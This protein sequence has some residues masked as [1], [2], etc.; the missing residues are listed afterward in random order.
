MRLYKTTAPRELAQLNKGKNMEFTFK[1]TEQ[2][3]NAI[4]AGLQELPARVA[5]PLSQKLQQQAQ[6]QLP[7]QEPQE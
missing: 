6:E 2:E 7:K 1:V 5:N 4:L 3:A